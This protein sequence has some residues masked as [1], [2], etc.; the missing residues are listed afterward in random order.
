MKEFTR[1]MSLISD[2]HNR[3]EPTVEDLVLML[4]SQE[5]EPSVDRRPQVTEII[6][7][8][9]SEHVAQIVGK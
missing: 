8:P 9:T 1:E 2:R 6:A 3:D 4:S 5:M 7:V